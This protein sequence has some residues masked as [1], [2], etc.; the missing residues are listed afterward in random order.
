MRTARLVILA[1]AACGLAPTPALAQRVPFF[2]AA[3]TGLDPEISV[4]NSGAVLDEQAVVSQDRKYVTLNMRPQNSQL[5]ALRS[6]TFAGGGRGVPLGLVGG[7]GRDDRR[8]G[9]R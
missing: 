3:A 8:D 6:F 2:G 1:I 5:L 9:D 4:V 7:A